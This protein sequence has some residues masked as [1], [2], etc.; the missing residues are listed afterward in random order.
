M[1]A[2]PKVAFSLGRLAHLAHLP[3]L[4]SCSIALI[5]VIGISHAQSQPP[6]EGEY[7]AAQTRSPTVEL[8]RARNLIRANVL[9][10]AREI[11]ETRGPALQPTAQWRQW[12][13]QLWALYRAQGAWQALYER[14]RR[15]PP[16][17]PPQIRREAELQAIQ[18]LLALQR[19]EAARQLIRQQLPAADAPESYRRQ[20][21]RFM[22]S[23]YLADDMI[24][25]ARIALARFR[26]D[27]GTWEED[28]L[29]GAE[30]LLQ[31][32]DADGAVNL[33]APLVQPEARLLRLYAR[34]RNRSMTPDQAI[35]HALDLLTSPHG[36]GMEREILAVIAQANIEAGKLYPLVDVFEDYLLAPM[37]RDPASSRIYP[38]F[39]ARD[40]L[41][42]Y[43]AIAREQADRAG[44]L[45]GEERRWLEHARRIPAKSTVVRKSLFAHLAAAAHDSQLRREAVD[46]Y[47]NILIDTGRTALIERLFGDP[48]HA[49]LG[50][51]SLGGETG[52]RLSAQALANG[53]F[54]LAADANANLSH[55]PE[56]VART[57]WL[58]QAGRIDILAG[59]HRPGAAKLDEWI[60]SF[61]QLDSTQID[62]VLQPIFD[63]Q[64]VGQ[65][66]LALD[67]LH[68]VE[69]RI[70]TAAATTAGAEAEAESDKHRREIAYWL[71][72]SY[73]GSGQYDR[74]ADLFLHSALQQADGFDRWGEAARFRAAESLLEAGL[75]DDARA[76]FEGLLA[77]AD[78]EVRRSTL[79]Q[80]LQRLWLL[81]SNHAE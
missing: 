44:L 29:L 76:L 17:F 35:D 55:L 56:G 45:V 74:A 65:H 38:Q 11:L 64:T 59:R 63:L 79:R 53:D 70:A 46:G 4:L 50:E 48:D 60:A 58:L 81:Q 37:P 22:I 49:G 52:L 75:F 30:V 80:K 54:R 23:A 77:R 67:L 18:A 73:H 68:E 7:Q 6:G 25:E 42:V 2:S 39:T 62:A 15:V 57:D 61:K 78:S 31:S 20:L 1:F 26:R 41:D 19:G 40:L 12:E 33:L 47:V 32:G 28:W 34:L 13:R 10:L 24:E 8:A 9:G 43:A 14:S 72:E 66:R 71:A 69:A 27:Y 21:R 36:K 3:R 16:S 51:L 5:G